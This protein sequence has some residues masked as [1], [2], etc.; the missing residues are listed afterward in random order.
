LIGFVV[1]RFYPIVLSS[2]SFSVAYCFLAGKTARF[3]EV[4]FDFTSS[5]FKLTRFMSNWHG[6]NLDLRPTPMPASVRA[7]FKKQPVHVVICTE[8]SHESSPFF[9]FILLFFAYLDGASCRRHHADVLLPGNE[10][11][12]ALRRRSSGHSPVPKGMSAQ[13]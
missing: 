6:R 9:A 1:V 11:G 7:A 8:V 12:L 10:G 5:T 13:S 3:G 2:I 4:R